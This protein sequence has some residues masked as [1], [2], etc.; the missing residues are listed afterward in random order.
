MTVGARCVMVCC[1]VASQLDKYSHSFVYN[2]FMMTDN[3]KPLILI[4]NDDGLQA[5]GIRF[6]ADAV[7]DFGHIVVV[8]PESP[9][10][11]AAMSITSRTPIRIE[12]ESVEPDMEVY[13]C[14]GTPTDCIKLALETVVARK[15]DLVLGGVNHGD[16]SSVNVHYSGTMGLVLEGC[17][18]H[19]PSIGFSSCF[20]SPDADFEPL[21]PYVRRIVSSVLARPLPEGICLNVNFPSLHEFRGMK[22]CR[23]SGGSWT[24]EWQKSVHPKGWT[25]YWLT[26]QFT[27]D[28]DDS[29][30]DTSA[31]SDGFVSVT[32]LKLD[33]TAYSYL[34]ELDKTLSM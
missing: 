6:L 15:P 29:E 24:N 20:T 26:G 31:L 4:S 5:K 22:V 17:M 21:R 12:P 19:I 30:T 23:M 27:G 25:Y 9:R 7:K 16:N 11:G 13:S 1:T 2:S 18:K 28:D 3:E 33:M 14:S 10:S 34:S 8:A 32:P